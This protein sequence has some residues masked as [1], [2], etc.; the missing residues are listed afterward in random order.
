MR[1]H[2]IYSNSKELPPCIKVVIP[3]Y[4]YLH[5]MLTNS[6]KTHHYISVATN[7][8]C[9][10]YGNGIDI[11]SNCISCMFCLFS[12]PTNL[13]SIGDDAKPTALCSNY[14][15]KRASESYVAHIQR[16]MN[17]CYLDLPS[18]NHIKHNQQY[19]N[20][21][22]FTEIKENQN[23]S[24]W[25]GGVLKYLSNNKN[26]RLG[27]EVGIQIKSVAR[28]G[29]LDICLLS[30][31]LLFVAESKISLIAMLDENR[32]VAQLIAYE[33]ELSNINNSLNGA[34]KHYKFL[35][36]GGS[37]FDLL[38]VN[39]PKR[40][41]THGGYTEVFYESLLK[42]NIFFITAN[43]LLTLALKK[44][45]IGDMYSIENIYQKLFAKGNYGLVSGG[46]VKHNG[47]DF[48]VEPLSF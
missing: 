5:D 23:I 16:L 44:L 2:C 29:R 15:G 22:E 25:A 17:G 36:V 42:H 38:P 21:R 28:G 37:E 11:N 6:Y 20:F 26:A 45:V 19:R 18:N 41:L 35:L 12:C 47:L 43:A 33:E 1:K 34:Y 46:V 13:I 32:Y 10:R 40:T 3:K 4:S 8:N 27:L 24:V 7:L 9:I 31:N 48:M 39:D 30:N 14:D